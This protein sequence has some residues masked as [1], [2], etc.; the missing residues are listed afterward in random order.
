[1]RKYA[2]K[3]LVSGSIAVG[4]ALLLVVLGILHFLTTTTLVLCMAGFLVSF[5]ISSYAVLQLA[6][7]GHLMTPITQLLKM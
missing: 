6:R 7:N 2:I 5:S 1:M 4:F 3:L